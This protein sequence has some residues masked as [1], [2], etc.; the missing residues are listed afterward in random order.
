MVLPVGKADLDMVVGGGGG[1]EFIE[2]WQQTDLWVYSVESEAV[3]MVER[4]ELAN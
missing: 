4:S 3:F 1:G 2:S